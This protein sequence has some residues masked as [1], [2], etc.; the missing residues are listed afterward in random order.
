MQQY[1]EKN[2]EKPNPYEYCS[3]EDYEII[4]LV[5]EN[6]MIKKTQKVLYKTDI[7]PFP[8]RIKLIQMPGLVNVN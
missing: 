3:R 5:L 4:I 6:G 1:Q 2:E 7:R 8:L